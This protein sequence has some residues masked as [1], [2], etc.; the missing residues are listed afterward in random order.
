MNGS[1]EL[2]RRPQKRSNRHIII[3]Q[4]LFFLPRPAIPTNKK[5]GPLC[6]LISRTFNSTAYYRQETKY[7]EYLIFLWAGNLG[8]DGFVPRPIVSNEYRLVRIY[9]TFSISM[10]ETWLTQGVCVCV[11]YADPAFVGE[12]RPF[13]APF[14]KRRRAI[15]HNVWIGSDSNHRRGECW[16]RRFFAVRLS[17][18]H[19]VP[20]PAQWWL[21]SHFSSFNFFLSFSV[22]VFS[23]SRTSSSSSSVGHFSLPPPFSSLSL[24]WGCWSA[25]SRRMLIDSM[26]LG[27]SQPD[28]LAGPVGRRREKKSEWTTSLTRARL[29]FMAIRN[30]CGLSG[31]AGGRRGYTHPSVKIRWNPSESV[32]LCSPD[33]RDRDGEPAGLVVHCLWTE[34]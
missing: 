22:N 24:S 12:L 31:A 4:S 26:S 18:A 2:Y 10:C 14:T 23:P 6:P 15:K 34:P 21:I 29:R 27:C 7:N 17:S 32:F 1:I 30:I 28:E 33:T 20:M 13:S 9:L 11:L 3:S 16:L 8:D 5:T 25:R 19:F